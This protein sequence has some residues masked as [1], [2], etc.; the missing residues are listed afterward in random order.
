D[1]EYGFGPGR[2]RSLDASGIKVES[3]RVD[4][5]EDGRC[6]RVMDRIGGGDEA[7]ADG[8]DLVSRSNAQRVESQMKGCGAIRDC[9]G[10]RSADG[11]SE[12]A[13]EGGDL[14]PLRDPAGENGFAGRCRFFLAEHWLCYRNHL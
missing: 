4:I 12:F 8:D 9:A 2:D 6:A 7:V 5:D 11:A 10:R 13:L 1:G 14:R 3:K